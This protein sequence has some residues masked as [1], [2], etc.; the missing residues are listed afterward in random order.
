HVGH[1]PEAVQLSADKSRLF[2]TNTNDDTISVLDVSG[3]GMPGVVSTESVKP[4]AAPVGA[5]PDALALSPD[6]RTLFVA[7]AGINAIELRDGHTGAPAAGH[8]L[9]IPTGYY[10]AQ[11]IVSGTADHYRLW[12]VNMKG[13]GVGPGVNFSVGFDGSKP[14]TLASTVQDG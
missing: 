10:P 5:H 9:Y 8:P 12:V 13:T 7:L 3:G 4:V 1:S 2:V 14:G 11:L 6:G